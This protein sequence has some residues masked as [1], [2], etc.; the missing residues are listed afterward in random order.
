[1]IITLKGADFSANYIGTLDTWSIVTT[2]GGGATYN[3]VQFVDRDAAF[4]GTVTLAD[5]YEIG[6]AGVTVTMGGTTL[7]NAVTISGSTITISIASVTGTV[8]ITVPTFNT[9]TGEEDEGQPDIEVP[10]TSTWY[11][12]Y[13]TLGGN[14]NFPNSSGAVTFANSTTYNKCVGVPINALKLMVSGA[15]TIGYGRVGTDGD[16]Y[17]NLGTIE[18]TGDDVASAGTAENAKIFKLNKTITLAEGERLAV[19]E[20]GGGHSGKI[21]VSTA[22]SEDLAKVRTNIRSAG[23]SKD[24]NWKLPIGIGYVV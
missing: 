12:D 8:Y 1:M 6:A 23:A 9:S 2:L 3:G 11:V 21:W 20:Y 19:M 13:T 17:T 24:E 22:A 15:G 5:G 14:Y 10:T 4:S 16:T 18:L 7:T